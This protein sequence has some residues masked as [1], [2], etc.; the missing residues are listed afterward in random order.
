MSVQHEM[1]N[2]EKFEKWARSVSDNYF[3]D[4]SAD[5]ISDGGYWQTRTDTAWKAWRACAEL[6]DAKIAKLRDELDA[7]KADRR[8]LQERGEHDAPCARFCEANAYQIAERHYKSQIETLQYSQRDL[9]AELDA[10]K[11]ENIALR[12]VWGDR[13]EELD[14]LKRQRSVGIFRRK[15][16]TG[17][18]DFSDIDWLD[19]EYPSKDL[20]LYA[21]P[22][23]AIPEGYV[24]VPIEL[25]EIQSYRITE[26]IH[27]PLLCGPSMITQTKRYYKSIIAVAQEKSR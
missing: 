19:G 8:V 11:S 25:S 18:G 24:L 20:Q 17:Y 22:V 13:C 12:K 10:F 4:F 23:P 14:V 6:K 21:R 26:A 2:K 16:C 27:G 5:G 9:K 1:S 3:P 7:L 15:Q